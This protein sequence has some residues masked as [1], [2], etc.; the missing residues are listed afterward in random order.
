MANIVVVDDSPE[1]NLLI[2]RILDR[3]GHSILTFTNAQAAL[4]YMSDNMADLIITDLMM[5]HMTGFEFT[6]V[7]RQTYSPDE[8]PII[9]LTAVNDQK[10]E[11]T[12]FEL[13]ANAYLTKPI[14]VRLM[15]QKIDELLAV[16][17][18]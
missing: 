12:A 11:Y 7:V 5:P 3:F 14:D 8:L 1:N 16:M 15:L 13:G 17:T 6:E 2:E 4:D 9:F 18:T 10:D